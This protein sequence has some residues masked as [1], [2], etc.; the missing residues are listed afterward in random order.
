MADAPTPTKW[1]VVAAEPV[2]DIDITAADMLSELDQQLHQS[3]IELCFAEMKG[4]VKDRLKRYG[5]F[6]SF[7]T[8][9]FFPTIGRAVS[10]FLAEHQVG[11]RDWEDQG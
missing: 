6:T 10:Q 3:G 4:P 8:E 11:W 1:V 7:G 9:N 2:T 5:L